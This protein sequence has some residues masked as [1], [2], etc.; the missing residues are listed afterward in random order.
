MMRM[1]SDHKSHIGYKTV[2]RIVL[3]GDDELHLSGPETRTF[4]VVLLITSECENH[5]LTLIVAST[6]IMLNSSW[7]LLLNEAQCIAPQANR[8][9]QRRVVNVYRL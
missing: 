5:G 4:L 2:E 7:I 6:V 9:R 1:L 3:V 8:V